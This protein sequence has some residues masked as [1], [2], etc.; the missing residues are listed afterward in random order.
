MALSKKKM[1]QVAKAKAPKAQKK[2]QP[3]VKVKAK[4]KSKAKPV[5]KVAP[6]GGAHKVSSKA[7]VSAPLKA[8]STKHLAEAKPMIA[9][10][11][12]VTVPMKSTAPIKSTAPVKPV[13]PAAKAVAKKDS[14]TKNEVIKTK[15]VRAARA[16][17][18][19]C[20]ETACDSSPVGAGYCRLH[21]IKNWKKV[22]NREVILQEGTLNRFIEELVTKYPE[23]TIDALM[24]DLRSEVEFAKAVIELAL[25]DPG[26]AGSDD[27]DNDDELSEPM[28]DNI[29]KET[30][31]EFEQF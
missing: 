15:S 16:A 12:V 24:N 13:A 27:F 17:M 19:I 7:K 10:N 8:A 20:R 30:F 3:K 22:K 14:V 5:T 26:S 9:V 25:E 31:D 18:P 6:Q 21:Y 2:A 4:A 28:I 1:A 23:K 29:K 11:P